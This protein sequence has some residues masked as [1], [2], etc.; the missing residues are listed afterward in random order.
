MSLM[1]L[2]FEWLHIV[3]NFFHHERQFVTIGSFKLFFYVPLKIFRN[4]RDAPILGKA[5]KLYI[6][7]M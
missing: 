7:I 5:V 4:R 2:K 1:F 6:E 3:V